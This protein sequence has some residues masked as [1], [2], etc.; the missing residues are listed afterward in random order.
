MAK[1]FVLLSTREELKII[2]SPIRQELLRILGLEG[3]SMT[4][5]AIADRLSISASSATHHLNQLLK[6]NIVELDHTESIRGITARFYKLSD[7]TVSIG[8]QKEDDLKGERNAVMQNILLNTLRGWSQAIE[9]IQ[10]VSEG[11]WRN[12]DFLSGV[13]HLKKQDAEELLQLI[14]NYIESHETKGDQT[15]PW[16]Y[17]LVLYNAGTVR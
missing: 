11:G 14:K 12:G 7:V 3:G 15:Q 5:K 4:A 8:T 6:L 16:E 13:L 9:R 2:M 17:A 10:D 1:K